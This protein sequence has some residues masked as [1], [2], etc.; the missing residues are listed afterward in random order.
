MLTFPDI[1]AR[2]AAIWCSHAWVPL[3][4]F[5][6]SR[7]CVVRRTI[8][9]L[10]LIVVA[11][12]AAPIALRAQV[13]QTAQQPHP[14]RQIL[15]FDGDAALLTVA[16][17]PDKTADFEAIVKRMRD[18]LLKS[19]DPKRR[20]QAEGWKVMRLQ[21]PMPDG[22]VAYVHIIDPVVHGVD[23]SIMQ[24]LYDVFPEEQQALYNLYKAAFDKNLSLAVGSI[25]VDLSKP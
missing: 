4:Q 21:Q 24:T 2:A 7:R 11:A 9:H 23:Y 22:A 1:P 3:R 6:A 10:V 13:E 20:Q 15:T 25:A 16:I 12:A 18:A 19:A 14:E 8:G 17:K 5:V